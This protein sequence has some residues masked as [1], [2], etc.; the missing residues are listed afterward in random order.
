M[1]VP[2]AG[3]DQQGINCDYD[4][5]EELANEHHTLRL[6]LQH[7][8]EDPTKYSF[9]ILKN[10]VDLLT[11]AV[12][13]QVN[14]IVVR[15]GSAKLASNAS[16]ATALARTDRSARVAGATHPPRRETVFDLRALH[17]LEHEG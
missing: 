2:S 15:R 7:V 11:P 3:D 1:A 10:N 14:D 12:L 5:L 8:A 9:R 16:S 17:A 6:M 4:R 13:A